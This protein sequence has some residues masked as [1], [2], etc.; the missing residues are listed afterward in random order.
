VRSFHERGRGKG[1]EGISFINIR[2]GI[3]EED[4][5]GTTY[6]Y[7]EVEKKKKQ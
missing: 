7:P 1:G 5:C 2:I 6:T 3:R 4:V